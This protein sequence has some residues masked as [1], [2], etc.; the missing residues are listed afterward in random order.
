M[1]L[2]FDDQ[3]FL[4]QL[5]TIW[6]AVLRIDE[7]IGRLVESRLEESVVEGDGHDTVQ[8]IGTGSDR[9]SVNI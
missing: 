9:G 2:L 3:D 7:G 1:R 8:L 4:L 6:C 5:R